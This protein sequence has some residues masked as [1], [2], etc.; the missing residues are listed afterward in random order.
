M[1]A[2]VNRLVSSDSDL[3]R[4]TRDM[5]QPEDAELAFAR[6]NAER[7]GV[8]TSALT[9]H[10]ARH[11]EV[12]VRLSGAQR[13]VEIGTRGGY[14]GIAIARGLGP[15]GRLH[16]FELS[17]HHAEAAR[18]AFRQASLLAEVV[19]HVGPALENLPSISQEAP[20]DLVYIDA[21]KIRYPAYLDWA[22]TH[23]RVGGAVIAD[24]AF[25]AGQ[26]YKHFD[27]KPEVE[28]RVKAVHEFNRLIMESGRYR[29]TILPTIEGLT[30]AIKVT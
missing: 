5:L 29:A 28:K 18:K 20:F 22:T 23:L 27:L 30:V 10:E 6:D 13:A 1:E 24:H 12:L 4:Y 14:T 11:L 25:E 26:I 3:A 21:D 8:P 15:A 16:T 7:C 9:P 2:H 19:I 17:L